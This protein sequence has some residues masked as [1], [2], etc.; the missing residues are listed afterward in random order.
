MGNGM[1]S[2]SVRR[3]GGESSLRLFPHGRR[4]GEGSVTS[5][6]LRRVDWIGT[7][8]NRGWSEYSAA[9]PGPLLWAGLRVV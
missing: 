2:G 8:T 9:I 3:V 5:E 4:G 1:E 7:D 6:G